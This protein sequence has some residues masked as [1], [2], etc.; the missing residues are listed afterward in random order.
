MLQHDVKRLLREQLRELGQKVAQ[1]GDAAAAQ[2]AFERL[3]LDGDIRAL[4]PPAWE[5]QSLLELAA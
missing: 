5:K 4:T 3:N 2:K 1:V